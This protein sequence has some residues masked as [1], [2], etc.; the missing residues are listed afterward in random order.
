[1]ENTENQDYSTEKLWDAFRL[2]VVP[3]IW[4]APNSRTYIPDPKSAIFIQT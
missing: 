3:I 4:G 2:G 1:I